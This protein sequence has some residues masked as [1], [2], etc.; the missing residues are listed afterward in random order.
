MTERVIKFR[1]VVRGKVRAYEY[2]RDERW[3][4]EYPNNVDERGRRFVHTGPY[5]GH[6]DREQFTGRLADDETTEVYHNDLV[7]TENGNGP[8]VWR[9]HGWCVFIKDG[10]EKGEEISL[11][12]IADLT[13]I[14]RHEEA[15]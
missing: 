3:F 12:S 10:P 5:P 7:D 6:G 15:V 8:V 2:V 13:V 9:E 11:D 14:G 4:H 1:V